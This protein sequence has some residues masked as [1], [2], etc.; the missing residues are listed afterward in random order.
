MRREILEGHP[1]LDLPAEVERPRDRGAVY[2]DLDDFEESVDDGGAEGGTDDVDFV[3]WLKGQSRYPPY[4]L[5]DAARR[6][7]HRRYVALVP[8]LVIDLMRNYDSLVDSAQGPS[9]MPEE[10]LS[11]QFKVVLERYDDSLK[12]AA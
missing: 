12:N 5:R 7:F 11:E 1:F 8:D 2:A 3:A 4:M 6:R 9:I 10:D